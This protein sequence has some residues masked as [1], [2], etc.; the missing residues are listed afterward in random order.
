M[1]I[2]DKLD[3]VLSRYSSSFINKVYSEEN[4]EQ[5]L[6][7]QAFGISPELKRENRQYWGRELGKC[8]E[9][10]VVVACRDLITY[11]SALRLGADTP[12]DLIVDKYAIDTKYRMGSGDSGTLKKF[13]TY[14]QST[15]LGIQEYCRDSFYTIFHF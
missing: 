1:T 5:D 12:C 10:L 7:M 13:K 11:K 6:L 2:E 3:L 9:T 8:W 4:D 14:G 15:S